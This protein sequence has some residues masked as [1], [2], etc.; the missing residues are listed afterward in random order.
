MNQ[1]TQTRDFYTDAE[2][3]ALKNCIKKR[4]ENDETDRGPYEA[5]TRDQR[6]MASP[7]FQH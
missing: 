1:P 7:I 3:M 6:A 4:Y 5:R 2:C